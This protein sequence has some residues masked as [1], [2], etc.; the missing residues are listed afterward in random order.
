MNSSGIKSKL[1]SQAT[2]LAISNLIVSLIG[3]VS[4]MLLSR[5]RTLTEYGTYSEVIMVTELVS[6][7][8]L[9]GLPQSVNYFLSRAED[10]DDKRRFFTLYSFLTAAIS[11]V[12]GVCL[13]LST[14]LIVSYFNNPYISTFA[15]VFALY[16]WSSIMINT[17]SSVLV[18]YDKAGKLSLYTL[19][20][21]LVALL[22]VILAT[23]LS[24]DFESYVL[25]YIITTAA[26]AVFAYAWC[27]KRV[28][29]FKLSG[30][31]GLLREVFAFAL[32]LGI[33]ASVGSINIQLDKLFIGNLFST[34]E[35]ALYTNASRVLPVTMLATALTSVLL[36]K[37]VVLLKKDKN[38]D[39]VML[40]G[41]SIRVSYIFMAAIVAGLIVF[42]PD[43]M[44]F[45]YSEKYVTDASVA[46][47][48]IYTL[49]LLF[50]TTY[51]GI[52]LN[53][54]GKTNHILICAVI[55]LCA[56]AVGN[57]IFYHW[58]GFIGP[59]LS[60]LLV[61]LIMNMAQLFATSK[62]I[63][64]PFSKIFPFCSVAKYS[65]L[66]I[67]IGTVF[68]IIRYTFFANLSRAFTIP[69]SI[70]LGLLTV[71][72]ILLANRKD[73]KSNRISLDGFS[74]ENE[75]VPSYEK[76]NNQ[77]GRMNI[78][79]LICEL[80]DEEKIALVSGREFFYTNSIPRL[81]IPR[82]S[83]SDGPHGVRKQ[84]GASD[85]GC[86][87]S[88]PAVCFPTAATTASSWNTDMLY[89]MGAAMAKE[90]RHYGV[91]VLLGPGLN[92]KRNPLCGR[93]FEYFSEDPYLAGKMGAA[94][95]KGIQSEGV[96]ACIKHFA[97]NNNENFRFMGNSVCDERA[98][99]E[100]Y[101]KP[102]ELAIR[103][104]SPDCVMSAY[105]KILGRYC[106]ENHML[107][108]DILRDEFNFDG[109]CMTDWGGIH[110]RVEAILATT[111]LEMPG[112]TTYCRAQLMAA[113]DRPE[114]TSA[115]DESVR[116]IL[117]LIE[118]HLDKSAT[119]ADFDADARLAEQIAQ[120]S[121]VLLKN[122]GI[123]PLNKNE[124]LAVIG[125]LFCEMRYQGSGSSM[126]NSTRVISPRD[127]FD[128][129]GISYD[130]ARGYDEDE[131]D[132]DD[133]LIDEA[134]RL[135]EKSDKIL[136]F[137]GLTDYTESEAIDRENMRLPENQLRL[138]NKI[139]TLGKPIAAVSFGGSAFEVPFIDSLSALLHMY[140]P[141]Q[142][143]GAAVRRLIYGEVSPSGKL[144][145]SWPINYDCV[146]FYDKYSKVTT[147][148]YKE[149]VF[150]GYRYY[151]SNKDKVRFPFGF[152]LSYAAFE[153][154]ELDIRDMGDSFLISAKIKN[155]SSIDA[156]EAVQLYVG[157]PKSEVFKPEYELRAFTKVHL[158]AGEMQ[159]VTMIVDKCS[160]AYFNAREKRTVLESGEYTFMLAA[161]SDDIRLK[162]SV[163]VEGEDLPSPYGEN[164]KNA[165]N[166]FTPSLVSD[167]I[168]CDM[169][170]IEI[171]EETPVLPLTMQSRFSD[172]QNTTFGRLIYKAVMYFMC[173]RLEKKAKRMPEGKDRD[174]ALKGAK[175]MRC[176]MLSNSI[177]T[178]CTSSSGLLSYNVANGLVMIANG[179][180]LG[181]LKSIFKK[182]K[183]PRLP[184]DNK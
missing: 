124:R 33:A 16:P 150:V 156:A 96:S 59:A 75:T 181:G 97:L 171:P 34:E 105:N 23:V 54:K 65:V 13:Y 66:A 147:E 93:N 154:S 119:D 68:A 107:L 175:F 61:A 26:F 152:G 12:V 21:A 10:E 48:R 47:F 17:L 4:S 74:I 43:A 15:Y 128:T 121:A 118:K 137:I 37:L 85:N 14:P 38:S 164:A 32:P 9:M 6:T 86:A 41:Y 172:L 161:S 134:I 22:T 91:D 92:I 116:R 95:I 179:K 28:G 132:D 19:V 100:I 130:F 106:S 160:L 71:I 103:D 29:G 141:G 146:P 183:A 89:K 49:T 165:Y 170:G 56:N 11:A 35:Y 52:I 162:A 108:R 81:S 145:E 94:L 2:A 167:E 18:V 149:S 155:V 30:Y 53:S 174:N 169:A 73:L 140:L 101:L 139:I 55:S 76:I 173:D 69:V 57:I 87:T 163:T 31:G 112:D 143:G 114:V 24:I 113:L 99:R 88:E 46:V 45:L 168:F 110:D 3:L 176:I 115:L 151:I 25:A 8:L 159:E 83:L 20:H 125:D 117:S 142:S 84:L 39:A 177:S 138:I 5:Y 42:A 136:L 127:A 40:W 27:I 157:A 133:A 36:P 120:D 180:I 166:E 184:E 178:L 50:K 144:A 60:T 70:A 44:S 58:L 148:L 78:D 82:L 63:K 67:L 7:V 90:A 158:R 135:A 104:S 62:I 123:L 79:K 102:F 77:G 51:F 1:S 109:V 98:M 111:D 80:T 64:V 126:I 182:E 153:Y 129:S 122:D 131:T 72:C